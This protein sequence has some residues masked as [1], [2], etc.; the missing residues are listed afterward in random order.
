MLGTRRSIE[1]QFGKRSDGMVVRIQKNVPDLI[2]NG[3]TS[4]F[5]GN[6]NRMAVT[7]QPP[8]QKFELGSFPA[9]LDSFE[10]DKT[11]HAWRSIIKKLII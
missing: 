3:A 6:H 5:P 9:P 7:F 11:G 2:G 10:C 8:C 4:R 1:K